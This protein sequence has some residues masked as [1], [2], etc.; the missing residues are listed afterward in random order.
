[1]PGRIMA[2]TAAPPAPNT[3]SGLSLPSASLEKASESPMVRAIPGMIQSRIGAVRRSII[4]QGTAIEGMISPRKK[5]RVIPGWLTSS[6][7]IAKE[8]A[9]MAMTAPIPRG[10][11]NQKSIRLSSSVKAARASYE[12]EALLS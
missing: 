1:M 3:I 12:S 6:Q 5:A 8:L 11:R 7:S 9:R 2:E 10:R 4:R